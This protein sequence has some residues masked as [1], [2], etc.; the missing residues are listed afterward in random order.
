[1]VKLVQGLGSPEG[2]EIGAGVR[3]PVGAEIGAEIGTVG[4]DRKWRWVVE[5]VLGLGGVGRL[6]LGWDCQWVLKS[7]LGL[8]LPEDTETVPALGLPEGAEIVT[9]FKVYSKRRCGWNS[10]KGTEIGDGVGQPDG[11]EFGARVV[12]G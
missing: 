4:G 3:P 9:G 1:M 8:G 5:L 10:R 6:V 12:T 2:T 11:T 7:A